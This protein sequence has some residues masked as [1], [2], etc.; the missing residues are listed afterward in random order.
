MVIFIS[1]YL[2]ESVNV[3]MFFIKKVKC[4]YIHSEI[5]IICC[6]SYYEICQV[7]YISSINLNFSFADSRMDQPP[8]RISHWQLTHGSL[9]PSTRIPIWLRRIRNWTDVWFAE[10]CSSFTLQCVILPRGTPVRSHIFS[11]SAG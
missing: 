10:M 9:L 11:D 3:V 4:D 6:C 7:L 1:F 2:D 5:R 8:G